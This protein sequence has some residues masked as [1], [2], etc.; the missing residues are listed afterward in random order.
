MVVGLGATAG[1]SLWRVVDWWSWHRSGPASVFTDLQLEQ[2][3]LV[4]VGL[5]GLGVLA[6]LVSALEAGRLA[7]GPRVV[8]T[9]AGAD[10]IPA[11]LL[12]ALVALG[13]WFRPLDLS[14]ELDRITGT[15]AD[16]GLRLA[17]LWTA[18]AAALLAPA[19]PVL[20]LRVAEREAAMGHVREAAAIREKLHGRWQRFV[21]EDREVAGEF[22][23]GASAPERPVANWRQE[24]ES[25][26]FA[27]P[28]STGGTI[29]APPKSVV[30]SP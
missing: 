17:P 10:R 14:Q 23:G 20:E 25:S 9:M 6:W 21:Q 13:F 1:L 15:L 11:A 19:D 8:R 18:R 28:N 27:S 4:L 12:I 7:A 5:A 29:P 3:F 30:S 2:A 26:P 24:T 16:N 22:A